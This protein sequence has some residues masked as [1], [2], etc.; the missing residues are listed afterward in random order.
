MDADWHLLK[1]ALIR[2]WNLRGLWP[3]RLEIIGDQLEYRTNVTQEQAKSSL[4]RPGL[5]G[6][7]EGLLS[8]AWVPLSEGSHEVRYSIDQSRRA[9]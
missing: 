1:N 9:F 4:K 3:I 2:L 6:V 7:M 8:K 5:L